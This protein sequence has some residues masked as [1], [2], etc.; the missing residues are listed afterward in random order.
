MGSGKRN[1][2][3]MRKN[4]NRFKW[5]D[6][7][8]KEEKTEIEK[9]PIKEEDFNELVKLWEEKKKNGKNDKN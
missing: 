2:S 9:K 6:L 1:Y 8:Q 7:N 3:A 4:Y 5:K